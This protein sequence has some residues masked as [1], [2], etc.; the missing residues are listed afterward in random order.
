[1]SLSFLFLLLGNPKTFKF[2]QASFFLYPMFTL[3]WASSIFQ[4]RLYLLWFIITMH[5]SSHGLY[6][7]Q[8]LAFTQ[9]IFTVLQLKLNQIQEGTTF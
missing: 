4:S 5:L 6:E 7:V 9:E 8:N 1:M 2:E 3:S